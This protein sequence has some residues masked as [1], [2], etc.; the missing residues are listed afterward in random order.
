MTRSLGPADVWKDV[1]VDWRG[2]MIMIGWVEFVE[3]GTTRWRD[4]GLCGAL[5]LRS[6]AGHRG[7]PG[8]RLVA[9]AAATS[10]PSPLASSQ[11]RR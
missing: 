5:E 6:C 11:I 1:D 8:P 9:K 7:V 4:P 10:D 2:P 3:A